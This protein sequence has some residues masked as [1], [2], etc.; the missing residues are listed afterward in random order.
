MQYFNFLLVGAFFFVTATASLR[1]DT[2]NTNTDGLGLS[3]NDVYVKI[4]LDR[5]LLSESSSMSETTD[6]SS[7]GSDSDSTSDESSDGSDSNSTSADSNS[8]SVDGNSTS[9][10]SNSTSFD[11]DSFDSNSTD[12]S[13]I[14]MEVVSDIVDF[15]QSIPGLSALFSPLFELLGL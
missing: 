9:S 11:S 15:I 8:T 12:I 6:G 14:P 1:G 10:D 13:D 7:D 4:S 2:T 3:I 5:L